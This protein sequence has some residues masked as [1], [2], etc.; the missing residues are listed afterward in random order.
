MPEDVLA[1]LD[2]RRALLD[3]IVQLRHDVLIVGTE[4]LSPEF[5]GDHDA[6]T[7]HFGAFD[8]QHNVCCATFLHSTWEDTPAWQ[9]RGMATAPA[10][11]S[12]GIGGALL[13]FAEGV[14]R[15]EDGPI[16]LWC[17]ARIKAAPFYAK[18]G[19]QY[20]SDEFVIDGV[21]PHFKMTKAL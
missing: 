14:L 5:P 16:R 4:R 17:N 12:K 21:G 2:I 20:A 10:Y 7:R 13:A 19:W 3:E 18:H 8:G 11:R 9:L 1:S 6:T 15:D